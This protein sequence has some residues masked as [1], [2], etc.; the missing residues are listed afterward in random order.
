M[1]Y[2]LNVSYEIMDDQYK[3]P[4]SSNAD[5]FSTWIDKNPTVIMDSII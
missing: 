2:D 3:Y 4:K 5:F 1:K